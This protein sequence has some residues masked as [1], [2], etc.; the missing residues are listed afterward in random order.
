[1]AAANGSWSANGF[2]LQPLAALVLLLRQKPCRQFDRHHQYILGFPAK[3]NFPT[4]SVNND[5]GKGEIQNSGFPIF[6]CVREKE[7]IQVIF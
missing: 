3:I 6:F 7:F 4:M 2:S 1:M 5:S